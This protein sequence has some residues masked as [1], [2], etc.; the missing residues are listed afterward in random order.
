MRIVRYAVIAGFLAL[1]P[2][3]A[4]TAADSGAALERLLRD[5]RNS[6]ARLD[7]SSSMEL[8]DQ[9]YLERYED[10]LLAPYVE[11][12]RKINGDTR[13]KLG[14]IDRSSLKGQDQLSY[15]I[16]A[17]SLSDDAQGLKSGVAEGFQLLPLNQFNGPQITFARDM[18]QRADRPMERPRDYDASIRRMLGFTRWLDQ[19]VVNMREGIKKGVTQPRS[20]TERM[21]SQVETVSGGDPEASIFLLPLKS[22]PDGFNQADRARITETYRAAVLGELIPAYRRLGE[23][24]RAEY[25][26]NARKTAGLSGIAGGKDMYLYLVRSNTTTELS[27]DE[28]LDIGLAELKR[29]EG[30]MEKTRKA[31]GFAGSLKEFREFLK[32]DA[33]FKFRDEAQMRAEF[34]RVRD[35]VLEKLD[36]AFSTQPRAQLTFRFHEPFVA[37]DRPAAEYTPGSGDGR[38][39]GTVFLNSYDLPSR[40]TYTSEAL[41]LHEGVPGHHLQTQYA[42]ANTALP[43]F[44]RFGH[45]SAFVEGWALYAES[46]G[47]EFGLYRDPY[48]K[49]G[50]LSFDAWRAS[51]L[52]V[53]IGMHWLSWPR[54]T[55]VEFL[56]A[57][58]TLSRA[59]AEEEVDRYIAI[60]GQALAYKMGE[61][62]ILDLRERAKSALGE[63]FDLKRFHDAILRDGAMPLSILDA[64]VESWIAAQKDSIL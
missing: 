34:I 63:K 11:A 29:I 17:W 20:V 42:A 18:K 13:A 25:L 48:Q 28:I 64:K 31:A 23:F 8:S 38:R 54:G 24:L 47:E 27:P 41:E 12:R 22:M 33:R 10:D 49:F 53:D 7:S 14:L 55:A 36:K 35:A 5:Y 2:A 39:P 30:E 57:H 32:T 45:E 19:A 43:R 58:T 62:S 9:R 61:R 6:E 44:R 46:L 3:S 26:P 56:M 21:I 60:P 4:G 40:P 50:A 1:C 16:F 37:P 51:R 52:V 15:D 59:E